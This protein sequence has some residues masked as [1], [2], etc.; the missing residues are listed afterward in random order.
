MLASLVLSACLQ[1]APLTEAPALAYNVPTPTLLAV[2]W[3]ESRCN[4]TAINRES[5]ATGL[6]QIIPA[7]KWGRPPQR[8]LLD[9]KTNV[10]WMAKIISEYR[11][12]CGGINCALQ[13]YRGIRG[14]SY[15]R[16]VNELAQVFGGAA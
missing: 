9:P 6:G 7:S 3:V 5:G 13:R 2:M 1:F 8:A 4:P 16:R 14:T 10:E 11:D 15:A 12:Y